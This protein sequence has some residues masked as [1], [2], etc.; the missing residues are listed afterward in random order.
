M[1]LALEG[2]IAM[3]AGDFARPS[4]SLAESLLGYQEAG[5]L[6]GVAQVRHTQ[7]SIAVKRQ[8]SP[9]RKP[10]STRSSRSLTAPLTMDWP[11]MRC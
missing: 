3:Q 10:A 2:V 6:V 9:P 11:S 1:A 7:G 8:I 4:D 5:D